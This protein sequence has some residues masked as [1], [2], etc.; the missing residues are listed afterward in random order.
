MTPGG[1]V[2]YVDA[3]DIETLGAELEQRGVRFG[4]A[5]TVVQRT[6][7]GELKLREFKDPDGNALAL[8]GFVPK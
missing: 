4:G 6:E 5:A 8:M 2:L 3:P 7:K 1:S